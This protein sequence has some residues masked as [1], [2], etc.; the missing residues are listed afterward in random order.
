MIDRRY[1]DQV[2]EHNSQRH[3]DREFKWKLVLTIITNREQSI[4]GKSALGNAWSRI[5]DYVR[6]S[7]VWH[8]TYRIVCWTGGDAWS[9]ERPQAHKRNSLWLDEYMC[10]Y[11]LFYSRF[12]S[13]S[14]PLFK[15]QCP[16]VISRWIT[17]SSICM[18]G[19]M[20]Q[21]SVFMFWWIYP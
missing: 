17:L 10:M 21:Q 6:L 1:I 9:I 19:L 3:F 5:W 16:I 12:L 20:R 14:L 2:S 13:F 7:N 15:D 4:R 18:Y 8:Y 11:I